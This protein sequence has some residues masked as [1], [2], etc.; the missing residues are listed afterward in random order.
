[1]TESPTEHFE[2]VEHAEHVAHSGNSFLSLVSVTIAVVAVAAA[3]LGSLETI[4]A[5]AAGSLKNS[6][7][8]FQNKATD[9]WNFYQAKSVKKNM[10]EIAAVAN[11]AKADEF[12]RESKRYDEE[13]RDIQ[14]EAKEHERKTEEALREAD[15]HE[16]RHHILTAAV[17]FLHVS[18]AIATISIITKGHRWPWY[19]ALVL[20]AAGAVTTAR[21]YIM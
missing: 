3:T 16:H 14:K 10:Y 1:M 7:V 2:H 6:A 19:T 11:T 9:A 8:L 5:G 13:S 20:A 17:T 4:E 21:A 12:T 18:I 15:H